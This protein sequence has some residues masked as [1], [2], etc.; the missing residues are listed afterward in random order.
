MK[1]EPERIERSTSTQTQTQC[2]KMV[3]PSRPS[4][5]SRLPCGWKTRTPEGRSKARIQCGMGN[6]P[7]TTPFVGR[8][9]GRPF[10]PAC[11][12]ARKTRVLTCTFLGALTT[13]GRKP[14]STAPAFTCAFAASN[15]ATVRKKSGKN[16]RTFAYDHRKFRRKR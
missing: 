13:R 9:E 10:R 1:S 8:I 11:N 7:C 14:H 12:R 16:R 2:R 4:L 15:R 6:W 3:W 5:S